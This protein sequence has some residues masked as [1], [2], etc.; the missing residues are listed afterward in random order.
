MTR[1]ALDAFLTNLTTDARDSYNG[2]GEEQLSHSM[3]DSTSSLG[4]K[5]QQRPN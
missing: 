5:L 1:S 2:S 3:K 4:K